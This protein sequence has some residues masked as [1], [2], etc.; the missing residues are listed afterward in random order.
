METAGVEPAPPRCK[1]GALPPDIPGVM[2]TGG[3]EPPQHEATRLQRAEL[4]NAQR[5]LAQ[6]DRPDSNRY[7]EAHDL[8][9]CRYTTATTMER[10]RSGSNRRPLA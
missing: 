4:T 3:V 8:G 7:D 6:G 10:G 1:R 5:P 2:R 9:C